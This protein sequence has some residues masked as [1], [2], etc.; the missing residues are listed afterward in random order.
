MSSIKFS[1]I[2]PCYNAEPYI[3][4]LLKVLD[5]QVTN[6]VEVILIDDG[7][8]KPVKADYKW[9]KVVRQRNKGISKSRN[10]GLEMAKGEVI[11][12]VDADDLVAENFVEYILSRIDEEWD[13]MDL[14]WKSLEDDHFCF[15]LRNDRDSLTN[16]SASTRVF[17]RS[18]IGDNRFPEKKDACEDEHFTRHLK[19]KNAKHI[20]ATDFM[21]MYRTTTPNS[22]SKRYMS[23]ECNTKRIAYYFD[24]VSTDMSYLIDEFKKEDETNEVILLTNKNDLPELEEYSQVICPA[25]PTRA[26][27]ARG[28]PSNLIDVI[29]RPV[30]SQIVIWTSY[31]MEIGGIETFIRSYVEMMHDEYDITVLYDSIG[32]TQLV[33][34]S[35]MVRC[36][37]NNINIPVYCDTLIINRIIDS[38][39]SNIHYERSVQMVHCLK[40]GSLHIPKERDLI[41][42]V[43]QAS[44][45]SFGEEAKDAVV[46]HNPIDTSENTEKCLLL[47]SAL[48]VDAGDKFGNDK[49]CVQF[50][51][52]LTELKIPFIWVYFGDKAMLRAPSELSYGGLK[53]NMK[54]YLDKADYLVQLSGAEAYSY[55]LLESLVS[56]TPVIVTPL[57]QNKDMGIEDGKNGYVF[58]FDASEWTDDMMKR[59]VQI[60]QFKYEY[61]K[62][63]EN[64]KKAWMKILGKPKKK[65]DYKPI[66]ELIVTVKREY[67]DIKMQKAMRAKEIAFMSPDRA[68]DLRDKGFVEIIG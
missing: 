5:V 57:E 21:Y 54:P 47:V 10:R 28:E 62:E 58:P 53:E 25:R 4:M 23:G 2:I 66:E 29:E 17:R 20:C 6:E 39:P 67:F 44:K 3:Y 15:K 1:I 31:T 46:I 19:L 37:K 56:N 24:H 11:A 26:I 60:P 43:S 65:S 64:I 33:K 68:Y 13:Y 63:N 45:D 22:N 14:S 27:I 32:T 35:K 59:I 30:R 51:Q 42:N 55:S 7:S 40:S 61:E 49:R 52:R 8:K 38:I 48:R 36:V 16:P 34:L 50:A 18:F 12:F 41:V 9:L